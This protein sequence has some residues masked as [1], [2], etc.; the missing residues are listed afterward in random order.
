MGILLKFIIITFSNLVV[1][2]NIN[3]S[4]DIPITINDSG[5]EFKAR[6][7]NGN[8]EAALKE[9]KIN[10]YKEDFVLPAPDSK[11]RPMDHVFIRRSVPVS[12]SVDGENKKINTHARTIEELLVEQAVEMGELDKTAPEKGV[13]VTS[14][15]LVAVI[16]VTKGTVTKDV[17]IPMKT[18]TQDDPELSLGKTRVVQKGESGIIKEEWEITYEN[19]KEVKRRLLKKETAREMKTEIVANGTK[20]EIGK[21]YSG[22]GTWYDAPGRAAS[23]QFP[24]GTKVRVINMESNASTVVTINDRGPFGEGRIIDLAKEAFEKIAPIGKGVIRV[25]VEEIL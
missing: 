18:V 20:I 7:R 8:V 22:L 17:Q 25:K 4:S 23:L 11:L 1:F 5:L 12:I 9:L 14:G 13:S 19:K 16:R 10:L 3:P 21:T 24:F 2:A 15:L 6:V